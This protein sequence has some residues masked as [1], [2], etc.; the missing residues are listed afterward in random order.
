MRFDHFR[1]AVSLEQDGTIEYVASKPKLA[2]LS[3]SFSRD[4]AENP[5]P[6][7]LENGEPTPHLHRPTGQCITDQ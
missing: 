7:Y 5:G 6:C 3:L 1:D 2:S 4:P